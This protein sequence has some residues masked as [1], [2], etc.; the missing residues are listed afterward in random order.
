MLWLQ[1]YRELLSSSNHQV[2]VIHDMVESARLS[3]TDFIMCRPNEHV[4]TRQTMPIALR[5]EY[6]GPQGRVYFVEVM[7]CSD[8]KS[9][10]VFT[11]CT[12]HQHLL[13]ALGLAGA[14]ARWPSHFLEQQLNVRFNAFRNKIDARHSCMWHFVMHGRVLLNC[15][16]S[17][18][19]MYAVYSDSAHNAALNATCSVLF[20][21]QTSAG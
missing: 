21:W 18:S 16:W 15:A 8:S 17:I 7:P 14:A 10:V 2:L 13:V 3:I 6:S 5:S 4:E 11:A 1:H 9:A 20:V 12:L 19:A